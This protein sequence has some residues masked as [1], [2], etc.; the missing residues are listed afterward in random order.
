MRN[1]LISCKVISD[2]ESSDDV[3]S[4]DLYWKRGFCMRIWK[5]RKGETL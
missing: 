2:Y 1:P 4:Y 5:K 3:E